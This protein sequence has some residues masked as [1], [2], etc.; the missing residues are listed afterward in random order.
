MHATL[1]QLRLIEAVARLGSITRAAEEASLTQP[2]VSIQIK[3]LEEQAGFALFQQVGRRLHLT[4]A[5]RAVVRSSRQIL[6]ELAGL[7]DALETLRGEVAGPLRVSGVTTTQYF[8]PH[9]LGEFVRRHPKIQPI[10]TVTN[11]AKMLDRLAEHADDLFIMGQVPDEYDVAHVPFLDNVLVVVAH[12]DHPLVAEQPVSVE[13]LARERFLVRES[14]SGTRQAVD[15]LF[16]A[17]GLTV[18]PYMELGSGEAIKQ[19]VMAGLGIAVLSRHGLQLELATESI[20]LLEC[21]GF[22]LHRPW[23][24]VHQ[25]GA[26][27]PLAARSFLEFLETDGPGVLAETVDHSASE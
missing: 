26:Q 6:D 17:S 4:A 25:T 7:D 8:L 19:G 12:P 27:L 23:N 16:E 3:R 10:L 24:A 1:K 5:G 21:E 15:R 2:A 13:R 11:R 22:P 20:T 18:E 14:G 9:L